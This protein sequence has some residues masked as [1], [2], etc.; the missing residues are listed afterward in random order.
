MPKTQDLVIFVPTTTTDGQTDYFTPCACAW[1]SNS[2][3]LG[4][5][6][7]LQIML[8]IC[9][10]NTGRFGGSIVLIH[11]SIMFQPANA[12]SHFVNNRAEAGG[13][14]IDYWS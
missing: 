5:S 10:T 8:L 13:A 4:G 3:P 2:A 11:S 9:Y 6:I 12:E 14:V 1:G 7:S